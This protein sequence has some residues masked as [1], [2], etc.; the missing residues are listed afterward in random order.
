MN[1]HCRLRRNVIDKI[2]VHFNNFPK[3]VPN[4]G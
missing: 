2:P 1:I 3:Q 4:D